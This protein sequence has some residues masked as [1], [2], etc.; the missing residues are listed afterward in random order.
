MPSQKYVGSVDIPSGPSVVQSPE[1]TASAELPSVQSSGRIADS[2]MPE[3]M[4][5]PVR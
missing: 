2:H 1:A 4:M 3:R 5:P